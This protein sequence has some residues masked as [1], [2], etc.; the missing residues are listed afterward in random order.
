[1]LLFLTTP[2]LLLFISS[3]VICNN[4]IRVYNLELSRAISDSAMDRFHRIY[5]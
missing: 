5:S 3:S 2:S 1:M 4:Q